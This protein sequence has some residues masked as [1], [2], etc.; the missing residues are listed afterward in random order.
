MGALIAGAKFRGE[1]EE[2]LKAVLKEVQS[3]RGAD[4]P[5]HRRAAHGGRRGQ[6]RRRNGRRQ[7]AE[8]DAGARRTALHRRDHA[9]RIS[10]VHRKRRGAG[11]A[12]PDGAGRP[13]VG[14]RHDFD[15]AR[16][17]R[18]LRVASRRSHQGFERWLRPRCSA[19][20]IFPTGSCRTRPS[21]WWTKPRR[22]CAPRSIPCRRELDEILRRQMQLE[23]EREA[24]KKENPTRLRGSGWRRSRKNWPS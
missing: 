24:L 12:I 9:R 15:S 3:G 2:R 16:A 4:H 5:V 21:T 7:S 14:G 18:T 17:A 6:G 19:S 22:S 10:Q 8:A 13:A 11:A 20:A 1:F 23:I